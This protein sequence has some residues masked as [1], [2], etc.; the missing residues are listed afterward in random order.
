MSTGMLMCFCGALSFGLL[1]T[2]SKIAERTKCNTSALVVWVFA[3]AALFMLG[4]SFRVAGNFQM[5]W[6]VILLST[7]LGVC[8]A[9][10]YFAFQT[11]IAR[12]KVTIGWLMM[13]LSAGVPALVSMWLY[14]EKLTLL[15]SVAFGLALVSLLCLF[16]GNRLESKERLCR[17]VQ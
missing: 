13:N 1:A 16:Q 5:T 10:A 17:K 6:Q 15:K 3:W 2:V 8:A 4:Q 12:G 14:G 7:G 9:V 11:S